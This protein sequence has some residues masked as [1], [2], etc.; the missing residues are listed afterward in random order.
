MATLRTFMKEAYRAAGN[1]DDLRMVMHRM[2]A[3]ICYIC[4]RAFKDGYIS[5]SGWE[6]KECIDKRLTPDQIKNINKYGS[7]SERYYKFRSRV[8]VAY[9]RAFNEA[10]EEFGR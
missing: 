6:C 4:G 3:G 2:G 9:I 7:V 5:S 8:P 1:D 10:A